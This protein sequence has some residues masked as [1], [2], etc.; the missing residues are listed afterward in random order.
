ML[1]ATHRNNILRV[2]VCVCLSHLFPCFHCCVQGM[3]N[4]LPHCNQHGLQEH[5]EIE[6]QLCL[7]GVCVFFN[8]MAL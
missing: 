2:C 4:V 8:G 5:I 7:L 6:H 1:A 3:Y